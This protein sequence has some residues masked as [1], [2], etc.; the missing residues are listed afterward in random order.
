MRR[1]RDLA[2]AVPA[3]NEQTDECSLAPALRATRRFVPA[4]LAAFNRS[5]VGALCWRALLWAGSAFLL[6]FGQPQR[7][8]RWQLCALL[9]L[10]SLQTPLGPPGDLPAALSAGRFGG[11]LREP[12]L[13]LIRLS[14]SLPAPDVTGTVACPEY[15]AAWL[16]QGVNLTFL[17][18]SQPCC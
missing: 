9:A 5:G 17:R 18:S 15:E 16:A 12:L 7:G 8:C 6:C 13:A 3:M 10:G 14:F 11:S 2:A 4:E 1:V